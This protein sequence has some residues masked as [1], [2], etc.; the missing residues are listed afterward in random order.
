MQL[1]KI[2]SAK[3]LF[4]GSSFSPEKD[5]FFFRAE[6]LMLS[7]SLLTLPVAFLVFKTV[8]PE[9]PILY[10]RPWGNSQLAPAAAVNWL[11]GGGII[12]TI[13]HT[14]LAT[15]LHERHKLMSR[16]ALWSGI[17]ILIVVVISVFTV[18]SRVGGFN[19]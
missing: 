8:P 16:I 14:L 5:A 12:S 17:Y 3:K 4:F 10:S 6:I 19:L 2:N 13:M 7:L 1:N 18:Y 11:A 9:I 15:K